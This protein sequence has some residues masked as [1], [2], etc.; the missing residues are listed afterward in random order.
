[1]GITAFSLKQPQIIRATRTW[2]AATL[3]PLLLIVVVSGLDLRDSCS[4]LRTE[5]GRNM[6]ATSN[7]NPQQQVV[8]DLQTY[9]Q[10][11]QLVITD[12][13]F[14]VALA[15]RSTPPD[16]VDTSSVRVQ[17]GYL[18]ARQL[19]TD[20]ARPQVQAILFYTG[21]LRLPQ[22]APFD[23]WVTTHYR[24]VRNYGNGNG[25]WIKIA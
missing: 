8:K 15:G 9:T 24:L 25:L 7:T 10:P 6:A 13:Q 5:H 17:S 23:T 1:M 20:A 3:L 22:L 12:S 16:L 4:Y 19:M 21:R 14:L 18:T 2:Q 11:N